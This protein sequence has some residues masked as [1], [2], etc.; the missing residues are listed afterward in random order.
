M[1]VRNGGPPVAWFIDVVKTF[2]NCP[3]GIDCFINIDGLLNVLV[4]YLDCSDLK[5][6]QNILH[7][8]TAI[9]YTNSVDGPT[10][11][12]QAFSHM[13][14]RLKEDDRFDTL[15]AS[16]G[17]HIQVARKSGDEASAKFVSDALI[18]FNVLLEDL[19][20]FHERLL[21]RMQLF[22]GSFKREFNVLNI[23]SYLSNLE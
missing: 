2:S 18:F 8:L 3:F 1:M 15:I 16:V 23:V 21:V 20:D 7:I 14:S 5:V 6:K 13:Q 17:R 19:A 10:R 9:A 4:L 12:L 22:R 11:I